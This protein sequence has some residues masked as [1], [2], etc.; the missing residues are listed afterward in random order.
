[1][2]R[3]PNVDLDQI[4]QGYQP[5]PVSLGCVLQGSERLNSSHMNSD[6]VYMTDQFYH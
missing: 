3:L 2:T 4:R 5:S 6:L 1:M